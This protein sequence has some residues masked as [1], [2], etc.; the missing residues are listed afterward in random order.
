MALECVRYWFPSLDGVGHEGKY[1]G[2]R[3][4]KLIDVLTTVA[5]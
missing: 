3:M 5:V 1:H 4:I 2:S